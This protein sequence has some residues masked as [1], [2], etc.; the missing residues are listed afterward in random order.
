MEKTYVEKKNMK[1][2]SSSTKLGY[3]NFYPYRGV[4]EQFQSF[5]F[6]LKVYCLTLGK[7]Q[8]IMMMPSWKFINENLKNRVESF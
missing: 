1:V 7:L 3:S 4:E 8:N 5:Q 6:F 2:V